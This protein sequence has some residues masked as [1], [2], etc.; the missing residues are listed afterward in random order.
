MGKRGGGQSRR[1]QPHYFL[2]RR[3]SVISHKCYLKWLCPVIGCHRQPIW[4][5]AIYV[6]FIFC[7]PGPRVMDLWDT[8][9]PQT[10]VQGSASIDCYPNYVLPF[11]FA[12]PLFLSLIP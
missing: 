2:V 12:L 8:L 11:A 9:V 3:E 5:V 6:A 7:K 4:E 1:L 10:A